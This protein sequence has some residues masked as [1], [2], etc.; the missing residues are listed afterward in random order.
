MSVSEAVYLPI[1]APLAATK[2][3]GYI[4]RYLARRGHTQ[5]PGSYIDGQHPARGESQL[6]SPILHLSY[7]PVL[8]LLVLPGAGWE[9]GH[10]SK[11]A[12]MLILSYL[13]LDAA[14]FQVFD[15]THIRDPE[16]S[17]TNQPP[18]FLVCT[19]ATGAP[20][21]PESV[22]HDTCEINTATK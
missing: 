1:S 14:L 9:P 17:R 16:L 4:S 12:C 2:V 19:A 3:K 6:I 13:L 8:D 7:L 20:A 21:K 15:L 11:S 10:G 5:V 22:R 18:A